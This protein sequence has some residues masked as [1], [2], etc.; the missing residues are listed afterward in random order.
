MVTI[1]YVVD[2]RALAGRPVFVYVDV[3]M[4]PGC[5][6]EAEVRQ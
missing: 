5:M 1:L 3:A 2:A 4:V 6:K